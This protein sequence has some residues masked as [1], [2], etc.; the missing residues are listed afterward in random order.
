MNSKKIILLSFHF[1]KKCEKLTF[2]LIKM[3]LFHEKHNQT[4]YN[5]QI[6]F[7]FVSILPLD[8]LSNPEILTIS[9]SVITN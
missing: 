2:K 7:L 5:K 6:V 9:P 1:Q 4:F 8:K 3:L